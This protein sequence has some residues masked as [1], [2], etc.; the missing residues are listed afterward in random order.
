MWSG[1]TITEAGADSASAAPDPNRTAAK[2]KSIFFIL[3]LLIAS[4]G[5]DLA[6]TG[7]AFPLDARPFGP[8]RRL[9]ALACQFQ[10]VGSGRCFR[11]EADRYASLRR[12]I[13]TL[14][15]VSPPFHKSVCAR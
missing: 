3:L 12:Q 15:P 6:W 4:R 7:H 1:L 9:V 13:T 8:H 2:P 5:F 10:F 14:R 11:Q